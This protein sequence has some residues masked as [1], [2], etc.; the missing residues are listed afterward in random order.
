M[1]HPLVTILG[2]PTGRLLLGRAGSRFDLDAVA[3]AAAANGTALEI[4]ASPH[5]L[6]L[7]PAMARRAVELGCDV[8]ISPDAHSV[9]ELGN[10][11]L[12][13]RVARRAGVARDRVLNAGSA[14]TVVARLAARREAALARLA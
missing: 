10:T 1:S 5:R 12:G 3:R 14:E 8:A 9:S 11:P 7:A 6:D 2:H 4:N 13:E